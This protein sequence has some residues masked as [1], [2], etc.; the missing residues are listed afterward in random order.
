[1]AWC[2]SILTPGLHRALII[3]CAVAL[4]AFGFVAAWGAARGLLSV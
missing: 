4:A 1:V 2:R 3:G